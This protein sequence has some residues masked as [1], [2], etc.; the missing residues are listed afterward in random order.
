ME[1]QGLGLAMSPTSSVVDFGGGAS[2]PT[3]RWMAR[4][5]GYQ[6]FGLDVWVGMDVD[7]TKI[8]ENISYL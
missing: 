1:H 4:K 3:C 8:Y 5:V 6:Q 7:V 2:I